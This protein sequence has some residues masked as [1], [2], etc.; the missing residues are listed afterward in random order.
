MKKVFAIIIATALVIAMFAIPSNAAEYVNVDDVTVVGASFDDILW[1]ANEGAGPA[2]AAAASVTDLHGWYAGFG[3][4]GLTVSIASPLSGFET[5]GLYGWI[6]FEQE[7]KEFGYQIDDDAPVFDVYNSTFAVETEDAVKAAG[8]QYARRYKVFVPLNKG[9]VFSFRVVAKLADGTIVKLNSSTNP[10]ANTEFKAN[11]ADPDTLKAPG[12]VV[13]FDESGSAGMSLDRV[14]WNFALAGS[15]KDFNAYASS[16]GSF[17]AVNYGG[18]SI[19]YAGWVCCPQEIAGF[20]Y[21]INDKVVLAPGNTTANGDG[22]V[23]T[24]KSWGGAWATGY[25]Q[26]FCIYVPIQDLYDTNTVCAV[27]QL[28]DGTIVKLNP[29]TTNPDLIGDTTVVLKCAAAP[30]PVSEGGLRDFSSEKG[31]KLYYDQILVNGQTIANGNDEVIAAKALVDGSDGSIQ[32]VSMYGWYGN[33]NAK[34][35]SYGY[36]IDGGDPV[37]GEFRTDA[38]QEVLDAGGDSRYTI[39]VDV[40]G[41]T[42]GQTH[43]I[44]AVAKLDNGDIVIFNRNE[45][46]KDRDAYVNYKAVLTEPVPQT[47]DSAVAMFAVV[48]AVA[49]GAAVVFMK[50]RAF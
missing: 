37:Y 46:G 19:G 4:N 33:A 41:L 6:G 14:F 1:T 36:T 7:I 34:V 24:V 29:A 50:K 27:V 49:M 25:I 38:E 42:D 22:L 17:D 30:E 3:E 5:L 32:T 23:D 13:N 15:R 40:T 9:G 12:N 31:D 18:I 8:G 48:L 44:Q 16:D 47:G 43:K 45:N 11:N 26:A 10:N 2:S 20:G 21:M 28:A 39:T 35:V